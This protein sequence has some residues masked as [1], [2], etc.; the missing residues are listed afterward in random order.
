ML[1]ALEYLEAKTGLALLAA[2]KF[3]HYN[4]E[5]L[6]VDSLHNQIIR[7][8]KTKAIALGMVD[9][10]IQENDET[11]ILFQNFLNKEPLREQ[12]EGAEMSMGRGTFTQYVDDANA[13]EALKEGRNQELRAGLRTIDERVITKR[14]D[15]PFFEAR[16]QHLITLFGSLKGLK[17]EEKELQVNWNRL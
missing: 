5:Y 7:G 11:F 10:L 2:Q 9:Y 14:R 3:D 1:A 6:Q 8:T 15:L 17:Q 4:A 16:Y 13:T 12:Y